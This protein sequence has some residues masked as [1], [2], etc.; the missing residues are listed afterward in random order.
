GVLRSNRSDNPTLSG[1]LAAFQAAWESDELPCS[2]D[3]HSKERSTICCPLPFRECLE[4]INRGISSLGCAVR[5]VV[6]IIDGNYGVLFSYW[7]TGVKSFIQEPVF[8]LV[9]EE[10]AVRW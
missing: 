6:T 8:V 5:A 4:E 1:A 2:F 3:P 10:A 7:L 9:A